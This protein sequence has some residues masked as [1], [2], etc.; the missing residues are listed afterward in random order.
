MKDRELSIVHN[1]IFELIVIRKMKKSVYTTVAALALFTLTSCADMKRIVSP[2]SNT[3]GETQPVQETTTDQLPQPT[4]TYDLYKDSSSYGQGIEEVDTMVMPGFSQEYVD[5]RIMAYGKKLDRW[6]ELDEQTIGQEV[7][8][9]DTQK[10]V[11]CFRGIQQVLN[12]YTTLRAA[13]LSDAGLAG[14][15]PKSINDVQQADISFLDGECGILL[16]DFYGGEGELGPGSELQGLAGIETLIAEYS[17]RRDYENVLQKWSEVPSDQRSRLNLE[18][19]I[20]YGKA[21]TYLHQEDQAIKLYESIIESMTSSEGTDLLSLHKRVADLHTA[22]GDYIAAEKQYK[23]ID[24]GYKD[25]AALSDWAALQLSILARSGSN[26]AELTAYSSLLRDYLGFLPGQDGYKVVW[27][28][29]KFLEDY[30]YS[31]VAS[32]VDAIKTDAM[33]VADEWYE[34]LWSTVDELSGENRFEDAVAFLQ[35]IPLDLIG[36]EKSGSVNS[37]IEEL[38]LADAVDRETQKM[39]EIQELQKQWNNGMLLVR[40]DQY[41]EAIEVFSD[42]LGTE[43]DDKAIAKIKEVSLKAAQSERRKAAD[44]FIRYTKTTDVES[45]KLLLI[46]SRKILRDILINYPDVEIGDKVRRNIDR[47]EQEMNKIDPQLL[48]MVRV[49]EMGGST[50]KKESTLDIFDQ[51]AEEQEQPAGMNTPLPVEQIQ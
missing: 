35:T 33:Q 4:D 48:P 13:L 8:Q 32:N 45:Q 37:K 23:L 21:L 24:D 2:P 3:V 42:L 17:D 6:K 38:L 30:P 43:Y 31:P 5:E 46:E 15:D 1:L 10:M 36:P 14:V 19:Q 41:D 27:E 22:S 26:G 34:S 16:A 39:S 25:M 20:L 12:G 44:A 50:I 49:Q 18:T 11:R 47:V 28:A 7:S 40:A 9:E 51:P 29:E